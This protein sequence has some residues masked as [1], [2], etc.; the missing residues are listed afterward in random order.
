MKEICMGTRV[1]KLNVWN[2]K[3]YFGERGLRF[4]ANYKERKIEAVLT[5]PAGYF[6]H[7]MISYVGIGEDARVGLSN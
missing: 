6:E 7:L 5:D 3:V 1:R 4:R 2:I